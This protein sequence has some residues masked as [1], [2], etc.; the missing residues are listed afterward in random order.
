[1]GEAHGEW[2]PMPAMFYL[3]VDDVDAWY[4]RAVQAGATSMGEPA[5]QPYGDRT[6]AVSDAFGNQWYMGTPSKNVRP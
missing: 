1:M 2:Q 6:A 3:N 4:R 5:N